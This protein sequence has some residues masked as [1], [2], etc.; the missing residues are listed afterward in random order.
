MPYIMIIDDDVEIAEDLSVFL[1]DAGHT[2]KILNDTEGAIESLV[3]DKPD[4]LILDV[5][6]PERPA[7]GFDL[8][9]KIRETEAIKDLPVVLLTGIN[10]EFPMDFCA[11]DID[12]KWI[13]VQSFLTKPVDVEELLKKTDE[14]LKKNLRVGIQEGES[15]M[16]DEA[17]G[18]EARKSILVIDDDSDYIEF[19]RTALEREGYNVSSALSGEEGRKMAAEILPDLII[20][21]LMMETW[22]EGSNVVNSIRSSGVT[23]DTPIILV[24]AVDFVDPMAELGPEDAMNISSYLKKP[25]TAEQLLRQ[26]KKIL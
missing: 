11:D 13:P 8:A 2:V 4:L 20:V 10:Q 3:E 12:P 21:D 14:L 17:H 5:M 6:F 22:T 1:E 18:R 7:G 9:R 16:S 24:S 19:V 25:I 26:V 15:V 23:K